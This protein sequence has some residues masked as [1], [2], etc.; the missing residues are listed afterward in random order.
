MPRQC[1]RPARLAGVML[2]LCCVPVGALETDTIGALTLF[3]WSRVSD[4]RVLTA[5]WLADGSAVA[6]GGY[7]PDTGEPFVALAPPGPGNTRRLTGAASPHFAVAPRARTIAYWQSVASEQGASAE[8]SLLDLSVDLTS[9]LGAPRSVNPAMHIAWLD[10][11]HV[12]F[13]FERPEAGVASL[14]AA[15]TRGGP[16]EELLRLDECSWTSLQRTGAGDVLASVRSAGGLRRYRVSVEENGTVSAVPADIAFALDGAALELDADGQL[17]R[18]TSATEATII[19]TGVTG[20]C[21]RTAEDALIYTKSH[22]LLVAALGGGEPRLLRTHSQHL[23]A[24]SGCA[25]A[26]TITEVC[27]W[28]GISTPG[29]LWCGR[30]GTE[31]ITGRFRFSTDSTV[32][33]GRRLWVAPRFLVDDAGVVTEPDWTTLK[34]CFKIMR[35]LRASDFIIA[36]GRS[37]GTQ[38]GVVER[39]TGSS[40]PPPLD[41][42]EGHIR[43]GAGDERPTEWM[44]SF[45]ARPLPGLAGWLEGTSEVG[46][47]LSV[48][49]ERRAL[50]R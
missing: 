41:D 27:A 47:M 1:A 37:V 19:D 43:I 38:G 21:I 2:V 16:P 49:V 30:L 5:E 7:T 45:R 18:S 20:L 23:P 44:S 12:V 31:T 33:G 13:T 15:D 24:L 11:T 42:E 46:A 14:F 32:I 35:V 3:E 36:E 34:A 28:S 9:T 40:D 17:I 50:A 8:L 26:P 6:Y 10:D 25:W 4:A 48:D 39:L 22:S 29:G